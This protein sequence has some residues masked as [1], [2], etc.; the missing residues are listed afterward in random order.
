MQPRRRDS[1][2]P[3]TASELDPG[4]VTTDGQSV[5]VGSLRPRMDSEMSDL[6]SLR[7]ASVTTSITTS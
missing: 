4:S 2:H 6:A 3:D 5:L 1:L 7:R